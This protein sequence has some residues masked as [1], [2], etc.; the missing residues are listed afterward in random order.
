[1]PTE[2]EIVRTMSSNTNETTSSVMIIWWRILRSWY[3]FVC[4]V[5]V[6]GWWQ[7]ANERACGSACKIPSWSYLKCV[8]H[9]RALSVVGLSRSLPTW[10]CL[11]RSVTQKVH[12][13]HYVHVCRCGGRKTSSSRV[14]QMNWCNWN[15]W[16][17][18]FLWIKY[19]SMKM[20]IVQ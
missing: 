8:V 6:F 11:R 13:M 5:S 9:V 12:A 15:S 3:V 1:M 18:L 4:E 7:R 2:R 20:R 10:S 19:W 14:D 17:Q 16:C